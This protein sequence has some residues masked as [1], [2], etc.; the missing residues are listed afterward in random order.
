MGEMGRSLIITRKQSRCCAAALVLIFF[1]NVSDMKWQNIIYQFQA[2]DLFF[3]KKYKK[4]TA[5]K[6]SV[7]FT[8]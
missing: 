1:T 7:S 2:W 4:T 5:L 3:K 6:V 8:K